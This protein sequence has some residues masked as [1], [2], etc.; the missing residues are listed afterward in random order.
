L[1]RDLVPS[2]EHTDGSDTNGG[3]ESL[4]PILWQAS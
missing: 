3:E 4:P 2:D 1:R